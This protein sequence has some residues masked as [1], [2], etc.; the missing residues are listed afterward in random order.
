MKKLYEKIFSIGF[1]RMFL[2]IPVIG[3]LLTY[4]MLSYLFFGV[5]TT[6]VNFVVF[7]ISDKIL[8]SN[9]IAD[10][11]LFNNVFRITFEDISTLIAWIF[12]VLFAYFTN[13]IWVFESKSTEFNVVIKEIVSFFTA[14]ILSFV[15][16]ESL[17]FMILRN[18]FINFGI[19]SSE[20]EPK[21]IAKI[22][23]SVIVVVFNYVM[24]KLVIFRKTKTESEGEQT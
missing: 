19:F 6:V 15:V 24:S 8:G 17:G 22:L 7:F 5:M 13:K 9:S 1:F 10:F 18:V 11:D 20:N 2:S 23:V 14:R 3:K 4:E 21:W 16:F 12:A